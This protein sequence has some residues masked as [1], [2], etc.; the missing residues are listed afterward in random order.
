MFWYAVFRQAHKTN[1]KTYCRCKVLFCAGFSKPSTKYTFFMTASKKLSGPCLQFS[2]NQTR[3]WLSSV[4]FSC[5]NSVL[6]RFNSTTCFK[7][8]NINSIFSIVFFTTL[9]QQ[10]S[11]ICTKVS[12]Q[13]NLFSVRQ[14]NRSSKPP[15][16]DLFPWFLLWLLSK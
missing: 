3:Q 1:Q 13:K 6:S 4:Q 8:K 2:Q 16:T 14:A 10:R 12:V 9:I 11:T 15:V 7:L 5:S